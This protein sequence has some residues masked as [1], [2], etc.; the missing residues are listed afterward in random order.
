MAQTG[1]VWSDGDQPYLYMGAM[2]AYS[3]INGDD[4]ALASATGIS[5]GAASTIPSL[6][7]KQQSPFSRLKDPKIEAAEKVEGEDCYVI[8][9]TS[10][11]SK[12][13]TWWIS[14]SKHLIVK[15]SRSLAPPE[16]GMKMPEFTD[17]QLEASIKSMGMKVTEESKKNMKEMMARSRDVFKNMKI[18]GTSTEIQV[19]ISSPD[20]SKKDFQYAPP[21]DAELKESLFGGILGGQSPSNN[22]KPQ[23]PMPLPAKAPMMAPRQLEPSGR[24]IPLK[25]TVVDPEG[26]PVSGAE[27]KWAYGI[28][29]PDFGATRTDDSGKFTIPG[30]GAG[31]KP[32]IVAVDRR[33]ILKGHLIISTTP[34][35]DVEIKL[36]P[37]GAITGRVT[38]GKEPMPKVN[39]ELFAQVE[40]VPGS[41]ANY[42]GIESAVTDAAGRYKFDMVES[43]R[44]HHVIASAEGY[45]SDS[46]KPLKV[47]ADESMKLPDLEIQRG[48]MVVTGIVVDYD[49]NPLEGVRVRAIERT[50]RPVYS[51]PPPPTGKDGRF[52]ISNLPNTELILSVEGYHPL[53][54]NI[55][56]LFP[57]LAEVKPGQTE[58]RIV[59]DPKLLHKSP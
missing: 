37:T 26:K 31:G 47:G 29:P 5:G 48:N 49:G 45:T 13:E 36:L 24:M 19:K 51:S 3:K 43:A 4:I 23:E 58:A 15:Y 22:A 54:N 42:I 52:T 2:R 50:S 12:K 8:S 35:A 7:L 53:Q 14:K 55:P 18:N 32:E 20:L 10:L 16:G 41:T 57:T 9:G 28:S 40:T 25:G 33:R 46:S 11:I 59:L 44:E 6:F 30:I 39:V 1:A 34:Q 38:D 17:E 56:I 21:K 27:V